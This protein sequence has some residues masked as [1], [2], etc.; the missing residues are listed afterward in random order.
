[1]TAHPWPPPPHDPLAR[2]TAGAL[3]GWQ[4]RVLTE[5]RRNTAHLAARGLLHVQLW[6]PVAGV[7]LI[8]PSI[9]TA[10][11]YEAYPVGGWKYRPRDLEALRR[12]IGREHPVTVPPAVVI[13]SIE[14]WFVE[15]FVPDADERA[16]LTP[17]DASY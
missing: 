17:S 1:M 12:E 9:L 8:T 10:G 7:S 15:R 2:V 16:A 5:D 4:V 13:R 14:R 3:A 6:H 11:R